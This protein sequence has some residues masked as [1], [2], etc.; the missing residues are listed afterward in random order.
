MEDITAYWIEDSLPPEC[1]WIAPM[2]F[3]DK[4]MWKKVKLIDGAA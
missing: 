1:H 3:E 2:A 4:R